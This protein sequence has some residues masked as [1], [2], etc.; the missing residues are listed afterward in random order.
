MSILKLQAQLPSAA[1]MC[2]LWWQT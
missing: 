1:S 2:S